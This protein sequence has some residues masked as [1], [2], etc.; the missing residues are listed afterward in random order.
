MNVIQLLTSDH[1]KISSL[2][3]RIEEAEGFKAKRDLFMLVKAELEIHAQAEEEIFY[4]AFE[5]KAG[6]EELLENSYEDHQEVKDLLADL[7]EDN[8]I[9]DFQDNL[10]ELIA[11]VEDHVEEEEDVFFP[12]AKSSL[13][14]TELSQLAERITALKERLSVQ[15]QETGP[16]S[17]VAA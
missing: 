7:L 6:F 5:G 3:N 11:C 17:D 1:E 2:F 9:E 15:M 12:R 10:D 4:P 14:Q 8:Q 16:R 13:D